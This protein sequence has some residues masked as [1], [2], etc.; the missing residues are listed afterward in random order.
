MIILYEINEA[1]YGHIT[2]KM[3]TELVT[4]ENA[5]ISD[6]QG[7]SEWIEDI[8]NVINND[9][10][11]VGVANMCLFNVNRDTT[12]IENYYLEDDPII[13]LSTNEFLKI[14]KLWI[15]TQQQYK[16]GDLT[17]LGKHCLEIEYNIKE[18]ST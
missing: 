6:I 5:L 16:K 10:K 17:V 15:K 8:E 13:T 3:P 11:I 2:I 4:L 7:A 18:V 14:V 12:I 1:P 9:D